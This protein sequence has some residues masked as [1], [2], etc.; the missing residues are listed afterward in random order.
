MTFLWEDGVLFVTRLSLKWVE[1][2]EALNSKQE[3]IT[4]QIK[5]R[6]MC[7]V[8]NMSG[9]WEPNLKWVVGSV[10]S[11]PVV[12]AMKRRPRPLSPCPGLALQAALSWQGHR[13]ACADAI[14]PAGIWSRLPVPAQAGWG[15]SSL[16]FPMPVGHQQGGAR[17]EVKPGT[18]YQPWAREPVLLP[19]LGL[20]VLGRQHESLL[21]LLS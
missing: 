7:C 15:R 6:F 11:I 14:T 19:G 8:W 21:L 12:S 17:R 13:R 9:W 1:A 3:I 4:Q 5:I 20:W 10:Y 18:L 16:G 2:L